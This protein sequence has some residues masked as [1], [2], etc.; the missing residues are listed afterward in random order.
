MEYQHCEWKNEH[1]ESAEG[2]GCVPA[3]F[4]CMKTKNEYETKYT[5]KFKQAANYKKHGL[6]E[7]EECRSSAYWNDHKWFQGA[8]CSPVLSKQISLM[9][10]QPGLIIPRFAIHAH[11]S[12][13]QGVT[14]IP[15]HMSL[16]TWGTWGKAQW[17]SV[18][19]KLMDLKE[20]HVVTA[21]DIRTAYAGTEDSYR[22]DSN[23]FPPIPGSEWYELG[24]EGKN[25]I[26]YNKD[27]YKI[28]L[29]S[30]G[31]L[32]AEVRDVS[33]TFDRNPYGLTK[34]ALRTLRNIT[35]K[36]GLEKEWRKRDLSE[37]LKAIFEYSNK[38]YGEYG[39]KSKG[40]SS[41]TVGRIRV[42]TL[43]CLKYS[44]D[45][46]IGECLLPEG[47]SPPV[48]FEDI[49]KSLDEKITI[50]GKRTSVREIKIYSAPPSMKKP[51]PNMEHWRIGSLQSRPEG[52]SS[53]TLNYDTYFKNLEIWAKTEDNPE[54]LKYVYEYLT[55]RIYRS[56]LVDALL[57][58]RRTIPGEN[59]Y[60]PAF[61]NKA[62]KIT[63][64]FLAKSLT[65]F[66][67]FLL[68]P[69]CVSLD[70]YHCIKDS[71][72]SICRGENMDNSA[73]QEYL[74]KTLI[75]VKLKSLDRAN[76]KKLIDL[77]RK[78]LLSWIFFI[79]QMMSHREWT[80]REALV[81]ANHW[82]ARL[83]KRLKDITT[84]L[85]RVGWGWQVNL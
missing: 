72:C 54:N 64:L 25:V 75:F 30:G 7:I 44:P 5:D 15:P 20:K 58:G 55:H 68:S 62:K 24:G 76:E 21:Q 2:G 85:L 8:A 59:P 50:G 9:A 27:C 79:R 63:R 53:D 14:M 60:G 31:G 69:P 51:I 18:N 39:K 28:T 19:N 83:D 45:C 57:K 48:S 43:N 52:K 42:D 3:A 35:D 37:V 70:N 34:H 71:I 16:T 56:L 17:R 1:A 80:D 33:F 40:D 29:S 46:I 22:C 84:M 66:K 82:I 74:I 11:G 67:S 26:P 32:E 23:T 78:Y 13:G 4:D 10:D 65:Q 36:I 6:N 49:K 47:V 81:Y 38:T 61:A 77:E 12:I 73:C 41:M